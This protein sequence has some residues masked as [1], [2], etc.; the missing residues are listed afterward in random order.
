MI[1][2]HLWDEEDDG[3]FVKTTDTVPREQ[4]LPPPL[5]SRPPYVE[6]QVVPV[7]PEPVKPRI[8]RS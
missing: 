8:R 6:P 1:T 3:L 2:I 7:T 4:K 5:P